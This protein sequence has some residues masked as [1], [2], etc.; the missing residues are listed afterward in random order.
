M[1]PFKIPKAHDP[2]VPQKISKKSRRVAIILWWIAGL[3]SLGGLHR[4]YTGQIVAGIL[5]IFTGGGF[6]FGWLMD[7]YRLYHR[8]FT[9][10][11]GAYLIQ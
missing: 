6:F 8:E 3:T 1:N 4:F 7:G 9:D 5:Y 10:K 11:D 2:S